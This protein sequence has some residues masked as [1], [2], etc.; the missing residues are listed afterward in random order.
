MFERWVVCE[1]HAE[2]PKSRHRNV[3]WSRKC[4]KWEV[5]LRHD[6]K[7]YHIGSFASEE[8]A[9]QA[10]QAAREARACGDLEAHVEALR[11]V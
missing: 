10:A 1:N 5:Q 2:P 9:A 8:V 4:R 6:K 3:S 7:Q 11:E